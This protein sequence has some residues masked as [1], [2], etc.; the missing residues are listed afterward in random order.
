M[1]GAHAGG[2][3]HR[4][5]TI[6]RTSARC[7]VCGVISECRISKYEEIIDILFIK[8]KTLDERYIFDWETC[9]HRAVLCD[10]QDIARYKKD[11]VETGVLSVPYYTDMKMSKGDMPKKVPWYQIALVLLVCGI[12]GVLLGYFKGKFGIPFIP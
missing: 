11:Q 10:K 3:N 6:N 8:L 2:I 7:L 1:I 4:Y 12:L 5:K 9:R